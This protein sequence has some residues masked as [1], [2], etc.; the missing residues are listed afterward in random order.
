MTEDGPTASDE[1]TRRCE[2]APGISLRATLRIFKKHQK[3]ASR[4]QL[5]NQPGGEGSC[6]PFWNFLLQRRATSSTVVQ[7]RR[8]T[9]AAKW[10]PWLVLAVLTKHHRKQHLPSEASHSAIAVYITFP[11]QRNAPLTKMPMFIENTGFMNNSS[12]LEA[13]SLTRLPQPPSVA[14]Q[15]GL[16]LCSLLPWLVVKVGQIPW[17]LR[18]KSQAVNRESVRPSVRPKGSNSN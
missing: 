3:A 14:T 15:I 4:K 11:K 12:K 18:S 2:A 9:P 8:I 1:T 13:K 5:N 6:W 17:A 7:V 16:P 10:S